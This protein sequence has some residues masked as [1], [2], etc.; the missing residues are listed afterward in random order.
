M[1][2]SVILLL[3]AFLGFFASFRRDMTRRALL[4]TEELSRSETRLRKAELVAGFGNWEFHFDSDEVVTSEGA[5][6]IY[7]LGD[8]IL[9]IQDAKKIPLPEYR[10]MLD[11][12]MSETVGENH[13]YDVQFRIRRL[14]DG[15]IRDIH[16]I[17]EYDRTRNVLFGVIHDITKQKRTEESLRRSEEKHRG[18]LDNMEEFYYEL[19]GK[20]NITFFNTAIMKSF[21]YSPDELMGMGFHTYV[22]RDDLEKVT[23]AFAKVFLTGEK[24]NGLEWKVVSKDGRKMSVESSVSL[25]RDAQGKPV[26]FR[27]LTR[28]ITWKKESEERLRQSEERYRTIFQNTGT[29]TLLSAEDTTILLANSNLEKLTG[30]TRQE[31]E[32]RMSWTSFIAEEDLERLKRYHAQRRID[33]GTAPVSY[34]ARCKSMSGE[35]KHIHLTV[36]LIPGTGDS[37][38]S[39][40]D[41]TDRK[42]AEEEMRNREKLQGVIEMA[43]AVCHE[44]NQPLQ[45]LM[46]STDLL[47]TDPKAADLDRSLLETVQEGVEKIGSLT[48]RI[49]RITEYEVK[50]YLGGRSRIIDIERSS[51]S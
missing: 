4:H 23:A 15:E 45:V 9:T 19:D 29:A 13:P 50:D 33:P 21:G 30:C 31:M 20:G 6:R 43:G 24:L 5:K 18:I 22:D 17:A 42:R 51:S 40:L 16:S 11:A 27:G 47:M 7:G 3:G 32:G 28:D 12:A 38:I 36:A 34:E 49:Q 14:S 44:L 48:R 41:M 2:I 37:V 8:S 1:Y 46:S 39:C 35:L 26:G 10:S 25:I